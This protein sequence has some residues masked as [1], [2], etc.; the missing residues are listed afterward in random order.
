MIVVIIKVFWTLLAWSVMKFWLTAALF[1]SAK[2]RT[3]AKQLLISLC[4]LP[5]AFIF[6]F[7]FHRSYWNDLWASLFGAGGGML[8][9]VGQ[10]A[11]MSMLVIAWNLGVP[12]AIAAFASGR[13]RN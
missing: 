7:A 2:S 3:P 5:V 13:P 10:L 11:M 1:T 6:F 12:F 9:V 8:R 4:F